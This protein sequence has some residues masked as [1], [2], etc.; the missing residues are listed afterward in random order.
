MYC[1]KLNYEEECEECKKYRPCKPGEY[2]ADQGKRQNDLAIVHKHYHVC[3]QNWS[4]V[5]FSL[6]LLALNS[7]TQVKV[8]ENHF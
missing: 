8:D 4:C 2:V 5:A 3:S 7:P 1:S 6:C